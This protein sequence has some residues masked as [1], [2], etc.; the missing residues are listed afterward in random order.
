AYILLCWLLTF[1]C[2]NIAWVFFR[3]ENVQGAIN[4]LKGMFGGEV[5]LPKSLESRLGVLRDWGVDFSVL[6]IENVVKF[7]SSIFMAIFL[8]AGFVVT[9]FLRNSYAITTNLTM[10]FY[11]TTICAL[12]LTISLFY[13]GG[14]AYSAF[15]YF[16]F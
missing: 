11:N 8:V 7:E 16:N 3:A 13:I 5:V 12:L 4:L 2:V 14:N 10:R 15:L 9:L 1:N 6:W